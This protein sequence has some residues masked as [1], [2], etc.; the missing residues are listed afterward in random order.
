MKILMVCLGNICR[1]PLAEGI[2]RQKMHKYSIEGE[3]DSCGFEKF[4][5]G[6]PPDVRSIK[7]AE[8]NGLDISGH[9]AHLF[10]PS[11]FDNF[12]R[13]YVMD[14]K[15]YRDV[16]SMARNDDDIKKVFFIMNEVYPGKNMP[17][18]DPY[19]GNMTDFKKSWDL[20]DTATEKI[21]ESISGKKY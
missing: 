20:L 12:D 18:P 19:M 4:H 7:I 6:D 9:K 13:I 10:V 11:Y 5:Q 14:N 2:M 15:N 1:S 8:E 21:A 16:L 17:V 3:V